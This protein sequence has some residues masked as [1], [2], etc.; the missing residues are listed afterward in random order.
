MTSNL[1]TKTKK[2][3]FLYTVVYNIPIKCNLSCLLLLILQV[4]WFM[5]M[6]KAF[7]RA[8]SGS[9]RSKCLHVTQNGNGKSNHLSNEWFVFFSLR[10]DIWSWWP[11]DE[12]F[13]REQIKFIKN[14]TIWHDLRT[15]IA[16]YKTFSLVKTNDLL[17]VFITEQIHV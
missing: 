17:K 11:L 9:K 6:L 2:S 7:Y 3:I 13:Y 1:H 4:Y 8:V 16:V 10:C 12:M 5:L 14:Q 15:W